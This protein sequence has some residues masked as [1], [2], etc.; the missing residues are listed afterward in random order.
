MSATLQIDSLEAAKRRLKEAQAVMVAA[1]KLYHESLITLAED[2]RDDLNTAR[3]KAEKFERIEAE[4]S[5][6][7]EIYN[8]ALVRC[9]WEERQAKRNRW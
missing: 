7:V 5:A 2:E 1:D 4:F 8:A 6:A 3:E 9:E